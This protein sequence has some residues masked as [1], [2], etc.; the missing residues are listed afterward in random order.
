MRILFLIRSLEVG[1]AERQVVAL[2]NTLA[3]SG[4]TVAIAVFYAGGVLEAEL[5]DVPVL[6]LGKK[7]RW[8]IGGFI[9]RLC[10]CV[11]GFRPDVLH[12]DL[13][14]GNVFA[15]TQ[16]LFFS[17]LPVFWGYRASDMELAAYG[18]VS[19][20]HYK[21]EC[22]L[23]GFADTIVSNSRAGI[24]HAIA[25]GFPKD[26]CVLVPNGVDTER[27]RPDK[28]LGIRLRHL[29]GVNDDTL[30]IGIVGRIDPAKDHRTFLK[31]ARRVLDS[32][33][34][35]RF[36]SVGG[37][38]DKALADQ[39]LDLTRELGLDGAM[40]WAG[41]QSD[42]PGV[43][44]AIDICCMSSS[45]EGLP[46]VVCE[47]MSCSTPCVVTDAGDMSL[48]VGEPR[49]VVPRRDPHSL[50]DALLAMIARLEAGDVPDPRQM[51]EEKYSLENMAQTV[52]DLFH[53]VVAKR[54]GSQ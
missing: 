19:V 6:D 14:S 44:N 24:E 47:A 23:S 27:F 18:V 4:H 28:T 54:R 7:G 15:L 43:Y 51:I 29:W 10:R 2:S 36:V 53:E 26:K 39:M 38:S 20:L 13:G 11:A 1:G 48:V 21:M 22:L 49:Q 8:D 16:K 42:M 45:T 40:I 30:L 25:H 5:K 34:D 3:A 46:N 52:E 17:G 33:L 32:R 41:E 35:I 9:L 37:V 12:G 31:A 50:G